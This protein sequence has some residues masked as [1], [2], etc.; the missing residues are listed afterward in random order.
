MPVSTT[1]SIAAEISLYIVGFVVVAA[2][3]ALATT[4]AASTTSKVAANSNKCTRINNK[5]GKIVAA[6]T[7]T[8]TA[9]TVVEGAATKPEA[10][11]IKSR[12]I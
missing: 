4:S 3:I 8:S 1:S 2:T 9:V 5:S 7:A 10:Y 6:A 12:S 11:I